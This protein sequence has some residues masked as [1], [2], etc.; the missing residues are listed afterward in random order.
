[1]RYLVVELRLGGESLEDLF[2]F[3]VVFAAV[4][5]KEIIYPDTV[6]GGYE[7][8]DRNVVLQGAA[9]AD[10]DYFQG[11]GVWVDGSRVEVD[12]DECVEFVENDV[13]V[14]GA[15]A[16]RDNGNAFVAEEAGVGDEFAVRGGVFDAIEVAG[17]ACN[18]G[19]VADGEDEGGD[20]IGAK[21]EVIDGATL[22]EDEFRICKV[23]H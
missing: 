8:V 20:F 4:E 15:D 1:M 23:G 16:G 19:G 22:I 12:V 14:V 3:V 11:D 9:G 17:D 13:D 18:A 2:F 7:A 10:A 6:C 5:V 21:V